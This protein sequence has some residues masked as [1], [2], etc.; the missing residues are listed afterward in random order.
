MLRAM[1]HPPL[2]GDELVLAMPARELFAATGFVPTPSMPV[3]ESLGEE[4]WFA[5]P[6]VIRED[7][8]AREV[9]LGLVVVRE[10]PTGREVLAQADG[11]I[12]TLITVTPDLLPHAGLAPLKRLAQES[13]RIRCGLTAACGVTLAGLIND[14]LLPGL[15]SIVVPIYRTVAPPG[16]EAPAGATWIGT[17]ALAR[18]PL[19]PA[20]ALVAR[21]L[22]Q[23]P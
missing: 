23:R 11:T 9:R 20:C 7:P 14:P 18:L 8:L 13:A 6:T 21:S 16:T 2:D 15:G 3:L 4:T 22:V 5:L 10:T 17:G 1:D 19:A 12:L